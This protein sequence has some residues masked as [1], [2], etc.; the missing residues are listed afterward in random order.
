MPLDPTQILNRPIDRTQQRYD[1]RDTILY[2]LGVGAAQSDVT[3]PGELQFVLETGLR[4]LPSMCSVLAAEPF[5]MAEPQWGLD[6][7]GILH[8][9]QTLRMHRA[10]PATGHVKGETRVVDLWDKGAKGALIHLQRCLYD[11]Q[12]ALIAEV[13]KT[14]LIRGAGGFGGDPGPRP[15]D[16]P[17]R[18]RDRPDATLELSTRVEQALIYRLSGDVNPLHADPAAARRA[19]FPRPILHGLC[20]YGIACRALLRLFCGNDP[21]A[22]VALDARFSLPLFPGETL[23]T[24]AWR[25]GE[26]EVAF[27]CIALERREIVL[28]DGRFEHA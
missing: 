23:R 2:A 9:G 13:G 25:T 11:E 12:G 24:D 8:A 21:G 17:D 27:R 26:R 7:R 22:L 10:L 16:A 3:D 28:Q 20:T 18:M 15:P 19:G 14:A 1:A 4:A 6:W 5:W